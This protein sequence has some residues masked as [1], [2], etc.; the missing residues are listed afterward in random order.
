[1]LFA[2]TSSPDALLE[3][4]AGEVEGVRIVEIL[5]GSLAPSGEPGDTL[6]GMLVH[7]AEVIANALGSG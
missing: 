2:E 3:T 7:N 1:V 4:V 5:E 6:A